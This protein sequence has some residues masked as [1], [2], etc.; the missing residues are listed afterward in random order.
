MSDTEDLRAVHENEQAGEASK[1]MANMVVR[2]YE[3]MIGSDLP[4]DLVDA[5]TLKYQEHLFSLTVMTGAL[6]ALEGIKE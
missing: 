1:D 6:Q 5:L 3:E 2:Y 4:P